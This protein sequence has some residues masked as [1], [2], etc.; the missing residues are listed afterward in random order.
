MSDV[1]IPIDG[2][3]EAG[4]NLEWKSSWRDEHLKWICG[5][6]NAQG[7]RLV[8]G[9]NDRGD[10]V[11]LE[12]V[13]A[14][15]ADRSVSGGVVRE[16]GRP[17]RRAGE[18]RSSQ[19]ESQPESLAA[20]VLR[21]LAAGPMSKSS[22]SRSLG[23]RSVSGQLLNRVVSA[24]LADGRIAYTIPDKP[25]SRLQKYRLTDTGT[26]AAGGVLNRGE[27]E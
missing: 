20:S 12:F 7:G 9:K 16:S 26:A 15:T 11:R 4:Q 24:L 8:I 3:V 17:G 19:P 1:E 10:V 6:A 14:G 13:F 21:Q 25:R 5:F 22:L 18:P 27:R 2:P 23:Q